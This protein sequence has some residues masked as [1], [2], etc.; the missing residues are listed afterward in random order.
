MQI[1]DIDLDFFQD[2][3]FIYLADNKDK[4]L[5]EEQALPWGK[6]KVITFL[7]KNCGLSKKQKIKGKIFT[8]HHKVFLELRELIKLHE[9]E[10]PFAL[11]HIDAHADL[12]MGDVSWAYIMGELLHR[13]LSERAYPKQEG[14]DGLGSSNYLSFVIANRWINELNFIINEQW[15]DDIPPSFLVESVKYDNSGMMPFGHYNFTIQLKKYT[16]TQIEKLIYLQECEPIGYEP[17]L[18]FNIIPYYEFKLDDSC[19]FLFLSQ[20]P[21]YTSKKTDAF[22]NLISEYIKLY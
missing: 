19:D 7:E 2:G 8:H 18:P 13:P 10:V 1:L 15:R 3:R 4:R 12:G 16:K 17:K 21:G 9:L 6:E 22:I 5:S 11:N 14:N 20:S